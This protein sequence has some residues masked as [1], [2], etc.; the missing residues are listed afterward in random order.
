MVGSGANLATRAEQVADADLAPGVT[1]LCQNEVDPAATFALLERAA[2]RG[3]RTILNLAPAAP[4]PATVL[5]ATHV[6]VVNEIEAAMA[7]GARTE[8]VALNPEALAKDLATRHDLTCVVTLGA[9]GAI[10][11][12]PAGGW[13]IGAL[14]V[15]PVDTTGA[16]DAFVGVLAAA[17]DRGIELSEAL[18]W[19]SVA[20]GLACTRLGAQTSQPTAA[21][22]EARLPDL[23]PATPLA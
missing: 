7:V 21:E 5:D 6:L 11:Q 22:I 20:A 2:R 16:G 3:A 10:A 17:L 4:V 23:A 1:L 15:E 14:P 18:R 9:A 12:G 13:R 19:A 8:A